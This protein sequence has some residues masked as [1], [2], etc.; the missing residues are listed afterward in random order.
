MV[1]VLPEPVTPS[2]TWSRSFSLAPATRSAMAVGWS[3]AACTRS[4]CGSGCRPRISPAART[5]RRPGLAVLEQRVAAFD[6]RRQRLH[7]GGVGAGRARGFRLL[8]RHVETGHRVEPGCGAVARIVAGPHRG[9]ARG[10]LGLQLLG[11]RLLGLGGRFPRLLAVLAGRRTRISR[12]SALR[13]ALTASS[14]ASF[15]RSAAQS[16][17]EPAEDTGAPKA[18][19]ERGPRSKRRTKTGHTDSTCQHGARCPGW[20]GSAV[21]TLPLRPGRNHLRFM[22]LGY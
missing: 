15:A 18:A 13:R 3:P 14:S 21:M 7:G 20:S 12:F 6:Q 5:V 10:L 8:H 22:G 19:K 4:P 16:A 1:K 17:I 2:S 11:F 9:A